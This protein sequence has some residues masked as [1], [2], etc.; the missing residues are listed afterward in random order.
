VSEDLRHAKH[1]WEQQI[2]HMLE[3]PL[4]FTANSKAF[5]AAFRTALKA[6]DVMN[7]SSALTFA[8][9]HVLREACDHSKAQYASGMT[10]FW[11]LTSDLGNRTTDSPEDLVY[12]L[13]RV[14][15]RM[16]NPIERLAALGEDD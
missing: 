12:W 1:K 10:Y 9:E 2:E 14:W 16:R 11:Q 7:D 4:L 15:E 3:R 6:W 5:E 13:R 8:W